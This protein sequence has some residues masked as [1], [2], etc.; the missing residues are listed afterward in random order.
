MKLRL[1]IARAMV[2]FGLVTAIG[3]GAVVF[4]GVYALS[5]VKIGGPLYDKIKL[6]NDLVADILPPPEYVIESYLEA[7]LA[8]N[9]PA[10]LATRRDRL[11]QL[12]KEYDERHEFW[13]KSDLD[14]AIKAKLIEQSHRE[15]QRFWAAIDKVF[16]PAL[17]KADS[18]AAAKSYSEITAAYLAHRALIDEIVT[19]TN[20]DN[21]A[22]EA[23][24]TRR[25]STFTIILWSISG[26]VFLVIGVGL[27]GVGLAVI[28]PMTRMTGVMARLAGGALNIEI[29][30]LNRADEVG[31]MAKAVQVFREN[32]LRVQEMESEQAGLKLR[33]E[34][35]RRAAISRV[36]DG[37]E[38]AIGRIVEVVSSAS[39]EI[40]LAA[41]GLTKTAETSNKLTA[42]AASASDLSS[43][44]AQSAA[45]ASEE[46]ASSVT[47]IGRQVQQS[48]DITRAAVHQA[49]QT[50]ALISELSQ[51]AGRI[52]EVVKL[53]AAVAEQTNLLALNATIEAA[54]AG[55]AGRGFAV[56]AS[57]VKA[58]ATQTAK[59]TEEIGA[60]ITQMQSATQQSVSAIKAI[61]ATIGQISEIS[62]TIA[63]AV[64]EQGVATQEIARNV[65]QAAQGTVQVGNSIADVSRGAAKTEEAA[66]QVHGLARSL[67]Q[68][69]SQLKL[70]VKKFLTTIRAV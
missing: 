56:V 29:P 41:G 57:E 12:K 11:A 18:G 14:P 58:L 32:A 69:G 1:T 24:A 35:D 19:K 30:S 26:L 2:L 66:G 17:A 33:A 3:P 64:E 10:E 39:S 25:V 65:Q 40:E 16:L 13:S 51:S 67:S 44:N 37:F 49:E 42:A 59:A 60:Q 21:A 53:I 34:E 27:L 45:S 38:Q 48:E 55:E 7:T 28:R 54:R 4:T 68:Q 31:A 62:T 23:G 61:S 9:N 20:D 43:A 70:E 47:E 52:G 36:A 6:G 50:N 15:V 22:I 5:E 8:L 63:A 46:M